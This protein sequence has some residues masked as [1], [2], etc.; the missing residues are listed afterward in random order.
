MSHK[1][2]I[3]Y[4]EA[5]ESPIAFIHSKTLIEDE[6]EITIITPN[7]V[8]FKIKNCSCY[9]L[10]EVPDY[11]ALDIFDTMYEELQDGLAFYR[12]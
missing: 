2:A 4:K 12:S 10:E 1:I 9:L 8:E 3:L 7:G 6:K 11:E 5:E